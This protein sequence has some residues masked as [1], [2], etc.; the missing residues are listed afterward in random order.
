MKKPRVCRNCTTRNFTDNPVCSRCGHRLESE[1][2]TAPAPI[3]YSPKPIESHG[4]PI[5]AARYGPSPPRVTPPKGPTA[6]PRHKRCFLPFGSHLA[7]RGI[8]EDV[9]EVTVPVKRKKEF[10]RGTFAF[11]LM[12][13]RPMLM[14]A[15]WILGGKKPKEYRT[16]HLVRVR[17]HN[18]T[19]AQA[20]IEG[21]LLGASMDP[22]DEVSIWGRERG[23]VIM[24][25][26]AYNHTLSAEVRVSN[27]TKYSLGLLLIGVIVFVLF[28]AFLRGIS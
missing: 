18:G 11:L 1:T 3:P 22:G 27:E 10:L 23:G 17:Q 20:R 12:I 5:K 28:L 21:D 16:G 15:A 8:V 7:L 13:F 25:S 26:H 6:P 2:S 19:V 4:T 9:R 24:V 14:L